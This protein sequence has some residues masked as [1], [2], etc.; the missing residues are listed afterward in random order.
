MDSKLTEINR[1]IEEKWDLLLCFGTQNN[2][3]ANIWIYVIT[4]KGHIFKNDKKSIYVKD[5]L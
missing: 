5:Q 1:I 2:G 3:S 4:E